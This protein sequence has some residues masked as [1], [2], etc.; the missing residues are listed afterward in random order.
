[1][2]FVATKN[3]RTIKISPSSFG[4]VAG[5]GIRDPESR[6]QD[7]GSQIWDPGSQIRDP[8]SGIQ[9]SEIR[10]PGCT[11]KNQDPGSGINIPD[12]QHWIPRLESV[13]MNSTAEPGLLEELER[14]VGLAEAKFMEADL[15]LRLE[16]LEQAKQRQ[17]IM[18]CFLTSGLQIQIQSGSRD[19]ITKNWKKLQL[20]FF[21]FFF[22]SKT[23][24]YL[25]LGLHKEC[26]S[27]RRSLQLSKVNI[28][29]FKTWNF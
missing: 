18:T 3:S 12:L 29:H 2:I 15:E 26:P 5:P 14:R 21:F 13:L 9:G 10:K 28:Q 20:N 23:T 6:I 24:I 22:L 7:P 25:S 27:Y 17:V 19:L 1:M 11:Y 8:R 4:A 16:E